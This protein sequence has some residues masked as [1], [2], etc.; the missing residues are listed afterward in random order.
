MDPSDHEV[1]ELVAQLSSPNTRDSACQRLLE[2]Y[3]E[4]CQRV[5]RSILHNAHDAE[6]VVDDVFVKVFLHPERYVPERGSFKSWLTVLARNESRDRWRSI[7]A[8][9]SESIDDLED[10]G[11]TSPSP[12][13][14]ALEALIEKDTSEYI[15][16]SLERLAPAH[17]NILMMRFFQEMTHEEIAKVIER[18]VPTVHHR[19]K[20]ALAAIE[21][22]VRKGGVHV[23][24]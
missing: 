3:E 24:R 15:H 11:T 7:A 6:E 12:I 1:Q 20:K 14:D 23:R 16:D 21:K 2:L 9:P 4:H 10:S 5:A 18:S 19:I 8:R 22:L 13:P 17:R